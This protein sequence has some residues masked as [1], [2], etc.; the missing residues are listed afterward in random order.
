MEEVKEQLLGLMGKRVFVLFFVC[1]FTIIVNLSYQ[2]FLR[3]YHTSVSS[4]P[5][6]SEF[7]LSRVVSLKR[8]ETA[9]S[10]SGSCFVFSSSGLSTLSAKQCLNL[11]WCLCI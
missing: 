9:R 7:L 6:F 8:W 10:V 1:L 2:V 3:S 11:K 5:G 4:D